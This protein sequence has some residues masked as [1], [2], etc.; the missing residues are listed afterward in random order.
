MNSAS[1]L[2]ALHVMFNLVWIGSIAA[3]GL[4]VAKSASASDAATRATIGGAAR[5]V[6]R[7]LA[8]PAFGLSFI[9]GIAL[10]ARDPAGYFHQHWFHGKL[11]AALVVIALHHVVGGRAKRAEAGTLP[12]GRDGGA[13]AMTIGLLAAAAAAVFFVI[14]R[15]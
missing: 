8:A 9:L 7:T 2:I 12:T 14:V 15:R 5:S 1:I 6:Y 13:K 3:V 4:L 10:V 11:T